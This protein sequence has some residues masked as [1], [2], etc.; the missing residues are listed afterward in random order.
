M[1]ACA[2]TAIG[3]M[4]STGARVL[5]FLMVY[6]YSV[7][8]GDALWMYFSTGFGSLEM[9]FQSLGLDFFFGRVGRV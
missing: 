5:G 6:F 9:H 2:S 7:S 3:S 1:F 4:E 8:Y